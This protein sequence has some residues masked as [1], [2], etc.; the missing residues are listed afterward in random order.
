MENKYMPKYSNNR[1]A[2]DYFN[3]SQLAHN[4]FTESD[5]FSLNIL[6]D[7]R[8]AMSDEFNSAYQYFTEARILENGN[9][10]PYILK[11]LKQH[12]MEEYKHANLIA[13]RIMALGGRI[14]TRPDTMIVQADCK[15]IEPLN[16]DSYTIITEA[17]Q[18]EQ[19]AIQSYTDMATNAQ[20]FGD[21]GTYDMF[22]Y[23]IQD[24]ME[25]IRDLQKLITMISRPAPAP[26]ASTLRGGY[27]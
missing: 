6:S 23:I 15:Y 3:R 5:I 19:C 11:E 18:G 20:N 16:P 17:I 2:S 25:H 21:I 22:Q 27:Q 10:K 24:E 14:D 7:L 9:Y 1:F 26:V 13:D 8:K 4:I 12:A